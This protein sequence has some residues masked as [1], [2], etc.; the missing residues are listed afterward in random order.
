MKI[1]EF[2]L[3][4]TVPAIVQRVSYYPLTFEGGELIFAIVLKTRFYLCKDF[5]SG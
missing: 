3:D 5:L 2:V 4:P 1:K